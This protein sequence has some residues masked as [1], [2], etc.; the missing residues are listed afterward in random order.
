[1]CSLSCSRSRRRRRR[2]RRRRRRAPPSPLPRPPR[3]SSKPLG[4]LRSRSGIAISPGRA[5][6]LPRPSYRSVPSR[7]GTPSRPWH[8]SSLTS[9]TRAAFSITS[10]TAWRPVRMRATAF[11]RRP[12]EPQEFLGG[13][14]P[15]EKSRHS[16]ADHLPPVGNAISS[17]RQH[18]CSLRSPRGSASW[19][20]SHPSPSASRTNFIGRPGGCG[21]KYSDSEFG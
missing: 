17:H 2:S 9:V 8:L 10:G 3:S 20:Q 14:R 6:P 19:S 16:G 5:L 7:L 4:P 21:S 18:P 1:V 11:G 15:D 13:K 12:T